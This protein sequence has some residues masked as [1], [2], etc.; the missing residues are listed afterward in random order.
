MDEV[1]APPG[2]HKYVG[3]AAP[4]EM[5]RVA[6]P[7]A[8]ITGEFTVTDEPGFTVN[9]TSSVTVQPLLVTTV[10]FMVAGEVVTLT[11]GVNVL[12]FCMVAAPSNTVQFVVLTLSPGAGDAVPA[13]E[14]DVDAPPLQFA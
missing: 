1:V 13:R 2:L 7:P 10:N 9:T 11:V 14:K 8:H 3:F 5:V 6:E 4:D 12:E